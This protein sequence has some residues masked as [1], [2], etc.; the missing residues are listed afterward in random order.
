[1]QGFPESLFL[2]LFCPHHTRLGIIPRPIHRGEAEEERPARE[3]RQVQAHQ[4]A[5]GRPLAPIEHGPMFAIDRRLGLPIPQV[6]DARDAEDMPPRPGRRANLGDL[7][8]RGGTGDHGER[9][10]LTRLLTAHAARERGFLH[11]RQLGERGRGEVGFIPPAGRWGGR[12]RG[13]GRRLGDDGPRRHRCVVEREGDH[14][15]DSEEQKGEGKE[16]LVVHGGRKD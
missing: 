12:D 9:H 11:S 13:Q 3:R 15:G 8:A 14:E 4:Q 6:R 7:H 5:R 16:M 10:E 1:M 2:S